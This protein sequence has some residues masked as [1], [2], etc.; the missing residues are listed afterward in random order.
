MSALSAL[1]S[2]LKDIVLF[3]LWMI[4]STI[5]INEIALMVAPVNVNDTGGAMIH[6]VLSLTCFPAISIILYVVGMSIYL[7]NR[8]DTN[9]NKPKQKRLQKQKPLPADLVARAHQ[10]SQISEPKDNNIQ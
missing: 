4:F 10:V 1:I 3:V 2:V 6:G 8:K 5:I 9:D 7:W